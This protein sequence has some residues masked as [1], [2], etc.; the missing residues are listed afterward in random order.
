MLPL[1]AVYG[2]KGHGTTRIQQTLASCNMCEATFPSSRAL[3]HHKLI[4]HKLSPYRCDQCAKCFNGRLPSF[5]SFQ[6]SF[7]IIYRLF[8]CI[9]RIIIINTMFSSYNQSVK[10]SCRQRWQNQ[11]NLPLSSSRNFLLCIHIKCAYR[12]MKQ[13]H[14]GAAFQCCV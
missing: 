8:R 1:N 9:H 11:E 7:Q 4:H 5:R 12:L 3:R 2:K 6:S 10:V 14:F 13:I